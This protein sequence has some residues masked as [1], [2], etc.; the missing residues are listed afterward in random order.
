[1]GHNQP[2]NIAFSEWSQEHPKHFC[3]FLGGAHRACGLSALCS[4]GLSLGQLSCVSF[5][6]AAPCSNPCTS[7]PDLSAAQVAELEAELAEANK[8]LTRIDEADKRLAASPASVAKPTKSEAAV[9]FEE[10]PPS[11]ASTRS[12]FD[13]KP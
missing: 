13:P 12:L 8:R 5:W 9:K 7:R 4:S 2:H 6:E 3:A 11:T 10:L 1:M